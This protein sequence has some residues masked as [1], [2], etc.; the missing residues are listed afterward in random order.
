M[1]PVVEMQQLGAF[2]VR[3]WTEGTGGTPLLFLHGFERHPGGASFLHRLAESRQVLAPEQPGYG[4]STGLDEVRELLDLVLLYRQLV[5]SSGIDQIDVVG[6]SWGGMVA[7]EIAALCPH[8][9]RRLVLVDAFGLWLDDQPT[10]DPWGPAD[11]VLA[12]KWHDPASKP[13]PEPTIFEP[14]PDDPHAAKFFNAQNLATAAKFLWPL[15]DRGLRR[16][17]PHIKAPTLVVQGESDGLV[18]LA[19]GEEF[20]KLI[21]DAELAVIAGAGHY[22]MIEREDEFIGVVDTFLGR[23]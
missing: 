21:P 12:A 17:L 16:R 3:V 10:V 8:L 4:K 13:D 18:P 5:E 14:D 2:D 7:G 20:V 1:S 11:D 6:H 19:Y 9:V 15:P 23:S 22:P